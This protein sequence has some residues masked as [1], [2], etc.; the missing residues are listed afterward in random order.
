MSK[1]IKGLELRTF[2]KDYEV[3]STIEFLETGKEKS[4]LIKSAKK[5]GIL[6]EGSRDLG[7]LKTI[8]CFTDR[9]NSNGAILPSEEF[10]KKLP[11]IVGKPMNQNHMREKIL[12]FY[13]DYKY[14]LKENKAITYAVF[15]KSN[16]PTEWKEAKK[17]QK[18]GKLSSSFEIWTDKKASKSNGD[19]VMTSI[20]LAGGALLYEDEDIQPSFKDAKVLSIAKKELPTYVQDKYLVFAS[21]FAEAKPDEIITA[22]WALDEVKKNAD[23]LAKDKEWEELAELTKKEK[24]EPDKVETVE[25]PK[26]KIET[27]EKP[28]EEVKKDEKEV[29]E[30]KVED[31]SKTEPTVPTIE[32]SGCG[33][34]IETIEGQVETKCPKCLSI[35]DS[36]G[37]VKYPPQIQDFKLS[38]S[39]GSRNWLILENNAEQAKLRCNSC[40]K[41]VTV[42]FKLEAKELSDKEQL[43]D[44]INFLYQTDAPCPQCSYRIPIVGTSKIDV[45]D[46]TCPRCGLHFK[47]NKAKSEKY[48]QIEEINE[49]PEDKI[50]KSSEKGGEKEMEIDKE[51]V[52]AVEKAQTEE[53]KLEKTPIEVKVEVETVETKEEVEVT[54]VKEE[55]LEEA[56]ELPVEETLKTEAKE[57]V[58]VVEKVE[59]ATEIADEAITVTTDIETKEEVKEESTEEVPVEKIETTEPLKETVEVKK[60]SV[61]RK[62]VKKILKLKKEIKLTK[63]SNETNVTVLKDGI[64]KVA[65][66]LIKAKAEIKKIKSEAD[67]K[68]ELYKSNAVEIIKRK[69]ELGEEFVKDLTDSDILDDEKFAT[70]KLE[71]E[72]SSLRVSIEDGSETVGDKSRDGDWYSNKQKE[73]DRLAF[74]NKK[75]K[76]NE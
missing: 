51:I 61:V 52:E 2:L 34:K 12:G 53:A 63:I 22:N 14:I 38:C 19:F 45:H 74:G 5:R 6:V 40:S 10:Q 13:I 36:T 31:D 60:G 59:L 1:K 25:K 73:I 35:L 44:K 17:L 4:D 33:E 46:L 67:K 65:S 49:L 37:K 23:K 56:V 24:V 7:L 16:Y 68:I 41:E 58:E 9:P 62:A 27:V 57:P 3:G 64:K 15:F 75:E 72:N 29:K 28:K 42:K 30:E 47:F 26:E 39:C 18:K 21:K 43:I 48:R 76:N 20:E 66:Q 32:C 71:K 50:E 11:Q 8:Y 69:I 55:K 54:E 70:A